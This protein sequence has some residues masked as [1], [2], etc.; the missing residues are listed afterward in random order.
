M[1]SASCTHHVQVETRFGTKVMVCQSI[2]RSA[3]ALRKVV[4]DERY[5]TAAASN[6]TAEVCIH[7]ALCLC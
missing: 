3:E 1:Q 5:T 4:M 2:M 7:L 6:S